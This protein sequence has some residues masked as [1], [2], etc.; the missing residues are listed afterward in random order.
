MWRSFL[1]ERT[2]IER[3]WRGYKRKEKRRE[4]K[5]KNRK[6]ERKDGQ[7]KPNEN[8]SDE[9]WRSRARVKPLLDE[10]ETTEDGKELNK[11]IV[12]GRKRFQAARSAAW[13]KCTL[14][15]QR[16]LEITCYGLLMRF[17]CCIFFTVSCSN[18]SYSFLREKKTLLHS[19]DKLT[20]Q[21]LSLLNTFLSGNK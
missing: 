19:E 4:K 16:Q 15:K 11:A 1:E 17:S 5:Q 21:K 14:Q 8:L 13:K 18:S 12:D 20:S 9:K 7:D 3:R 10:Q 6:K 2:N